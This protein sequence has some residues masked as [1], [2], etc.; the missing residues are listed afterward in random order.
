M[1]CHYRW[2]QSER[3]SGVLTKVTC[4]ILR[5][6]PKKLSTLSK[7]FRQSPGRRWLW[8]PTQNCTMNFP[9][10]SVFLTTLHLSHRLQTAAVEHIERI[11]CLSVCLLGCLYVS[12]PVRVCQSMSLLVFLWF[13]GTFSSVN[14][15]FK[16][17]IKQPYVICHLL[18]VLT[19]HHVAVEWAD[20]WFSCD[21]Q[22]VD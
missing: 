1:V 10:R 5:R 2:C 9:T 6:V 19:V 8:R 12:L 7:R 14:H 13:C 15:Q 16:P 21:Q 3:S 22:S 20:S 11:V 18:L 4:H 17:T